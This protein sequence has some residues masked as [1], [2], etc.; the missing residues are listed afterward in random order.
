MPHMRILDDRS[1]KIIRQ[2]K[3]I[4]MDTNDLLK[5]QNADNTDLDLVRDLLIQIDDLFL[6]VVAG[7]YNAGKS[8]FINAL[9][10]G[11]FL[12]TGITPTT[13]AIHIL[14]YGDERESEI[15]RSGQ[16]VEKI[17]VKI[18][19]GVTIVDTPGTNAVLREHEI[20]TNEYIP[21]SDLVLFITSADRPFTESEKVFLEK[22][23][24][25]GKKIVFVINKI[26]ILDSSES[27]LEV[28]DYISQNARVL[29]GMEAKIFSVSAK[30]SLE[31]KQREN[32]PDANLKEI[33]D[34]I[35]ATLGSDE[36]ISLKLNSPLGVSE[37]ICQKYT[38]RI[39]EQ[40]ELLSADVRL[41]EDIQNQL[42]L[43]K[44][45]MLQQF[46]FRYADIDNALLVFEKRGLEFFENTFRFARIFDLLNKDRIQSEYQ[47]QVSK[48]LEKQ[49][50]ASIN[51]LIDWLVGEDLKQ[52]Q[53]ITQKI[54][55]RRHQHRERIIEDPE[56]RQ[57]RFERQKIID[58][59]N[60]ESSNI[61]EQFNKDE[62]ASKIAEQAQMSVAASAAI[63]AGALGLGAIVTLLATTASADVTGV[64]L[65]G[66]TAALGLFIIPAKKKNIKSIFS[67]KIGEVRNQLSGILTSEF[68]KQIDQ[69]VN[70]IQETISPYDRFI[71]SEIQRL[72]SA[73]SNAA[74]IQ[75]A[76]WS[77]RRDIS[78]KFSR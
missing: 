75:D 12:K 58:A 1:G 13:S 43:F 6:I 34:F 68:E 24:D 65:A 22:I 67:K 76:V 2:I 30:Q 46:R 4:L 7:E 9:L 59:V 41:L 29:L 60:R 38:N 49:I 61:I 10:G 36:Y 28:E 72:T 11:N 66:L 42:A 53:T 35:S 55:D 45:D 31:Q 50:D 71:R 37:N 51:E 19:Q 56:F 77:A 78:R 44:Q 33:E 17:P 15:I 70:H 8:A 69:V 32:K 18:L 52:W 21:R 5:G 39:K 74:Q 47:K 54:D 57:I 26:D 3:Q 73:K 63:E 16:T 40:E 27:L 48:G 25:W 64:L 14:Q 20:L 62:E 23:R